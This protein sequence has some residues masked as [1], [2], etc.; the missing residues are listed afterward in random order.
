LHT[1]ALFG[2]G[3]FMNPAGSGI[4]FL[5]VRVVDETSTVKL[6]VPES[7]V[8]IAP[9]ELE[10]TFDKFYQVRRPR[11]RRTGTT[12]AAEPPVEFVAP[13][14]VRSAAVR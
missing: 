13:A 12:F 8:G 9:S 3:L 7:G 10:R 5:D 14:V 4:P 1:A 11:G 2:T 6:L